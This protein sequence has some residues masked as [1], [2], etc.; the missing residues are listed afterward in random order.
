M[1]IDRPLHHPTGWGVR[2]RERDLICGHFEEIRP[3]KKRVG[4]RR[5]PSAKTV[6]GQELDDPH[7]CYRGQISYSPTVLRPKRLSHASSVTATVSAAHRFQS[8]L[9]RGRGWTSIR[10]GAG[11]IISGTAPR[12]PRTGRRRLLLVHIYGNGYCCL[13]LQPGES[14]SSNQSGVLRGPGSFEA[15]PSDEAAWAI[16]DLPEHTASST[17][18]LSWYC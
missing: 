17:C 15:E 14:E 5:S 16:E 10:A 3:A 4:T 11:D 12:A 8:V 13:I 2:D 1:K 9:L 6:R 18:W 7:C